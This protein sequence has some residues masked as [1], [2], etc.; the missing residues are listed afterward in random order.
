MARA[1][2]VRK[3]PFVAAFKTFFSGLPK[4]ANIIGMTTLYDILA[5][6]DTAAA[7]GDPLIHNW[8]QVRGCIALFGHACGGLDRCPI[9]AFEDRFPEY[10]ESLD[11]ADQNGFPSKHTYRLARAQIIQLLI[12]LDLMRNPWDKLYGLIRKTNPGVQDLGQ[13]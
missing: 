6:G 10:F 12:Q 7:A 2:K 13:P 3:P 1:A 11:P 8:V 4:T 5:L 9:T